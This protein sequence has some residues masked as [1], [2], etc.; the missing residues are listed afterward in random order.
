M[1]Q[2]GSVMAAWPKVRAAPRPVRAWSRSYELGR[3][4]VNPLVALIAGEAGMA[5]RLLVL[6]AK[7]AHGRCVLCRAGPQAGRVRW[8]CTIASAALDAASPGASEPL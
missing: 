4:P 1:D 2:M 5:D 8:P 7:D 6:H 3:R